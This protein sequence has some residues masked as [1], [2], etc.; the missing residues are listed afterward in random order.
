M[1]K[2]GS[3]RA[4]EVA[5]DKGKQRGNRCWSPAWNGGESTG[6]ESGRIICE[7]LEK[8]DDEYDDD[9]LK[10]MRKVISYV[11]RHQAQG[12]S[13]DV[14]HS[15]WR[16]SLMNWYAHL[17]M[18]LLHHTYIPHCPVVASS[19][20]RERDELLSQKHMH[21]TCV[22]CCSQQSCVLMLS[23]KRAKYRRVK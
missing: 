22:I 20:H 16:Y 6:H 21:I 8:G 17:Y 2:H 10:H 3:Q 5:E 11:H 23:S 1:C 7:L 14:E 18:Q 13:K 9:D 15:K 4:A 12:P 19:W